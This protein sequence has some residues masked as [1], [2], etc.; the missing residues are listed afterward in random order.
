MLNVVTREGQKVLA[1]V[2]T[3]LLLF[4]QQAGYKFGGYLVYI[5][6]VFEISQN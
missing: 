1:C 2:D 4:T 3:V 6:I 5:Q